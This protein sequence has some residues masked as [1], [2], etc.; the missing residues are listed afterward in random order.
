V[1][2]FVFCFFFL[3]RKK[4]GLYSKESGNGGKFLF[5]KTCLSELCDHNVKHNCRAKMSK[6][7]EIE[8]RSQF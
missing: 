2:S 3:E 8:S 4:K 7:N 5:T 6:K 1:E